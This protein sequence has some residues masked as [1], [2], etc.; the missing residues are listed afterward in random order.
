MKKLITRDTVTIVLAVLVVAQFIL[1]GWTIQRQDNI[2][3]RHIQTM[4]TMQQNLTA[5]S[6]GLSYQQ[7]AVSPSDNKIYLPQL[8]LALP[9]TTL[10]T[11]L[12]YSPD[13]AYQTGSNKAPSGP[14]NEATVSIFG[15]AS[16]TQTQSQFDCSGLVRIKFEA[17]PNP[18]N[19]SET[20]IGGVKMANGKTLQIYANH[21]S[22]CQKEWSITQANADAVA[23]L[24][25]QA[26]SY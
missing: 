2:N 5:V 4:N 15:T 26:Q 21:R 7:V 12:L 9:L 19:P 10:G 8:G 17:T 13:A 3:S 6:N 11:S 14:A 24:F 16:A 18:Y 22:A 1:W 25:K 20:P 23:D